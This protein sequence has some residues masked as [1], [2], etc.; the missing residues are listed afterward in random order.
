VGRVQIMS[1]P[2][3]LEQKRPSDG[4]LLVRD[5]PDELVRI[6]CRHC[7]PDRAVSAGELGGTL[8]AGGRDAGRARPPGDL[9]PMARSGP[10][11]AVHDTCVA[12]LPEP[13]RRVSNLALH[14]TTV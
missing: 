9:L 7:D 11:K 6:A 5:Y 2:G 8:W 1:R 13:A 10:V 3:W 12:S 4:A 14:M